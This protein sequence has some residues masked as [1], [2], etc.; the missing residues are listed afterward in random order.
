MAN[1]MQEMGTLMDS[2]EG[3]E[4]ALFAQTTDPAGGPL[5]ENAVLLQEDE[6]HNKSGGGGTGCL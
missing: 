4:A 3:L 5:P 2:H 6:M 1:F